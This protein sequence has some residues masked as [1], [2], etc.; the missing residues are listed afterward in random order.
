[1]RITPQGRLEGLHGFFRSPGLKHDITDKI[2]R[3][4][5]VGLLPGNFLQHGQSLIIVHH[6]WIKLAQHGQSI[7]QRLVNGLRFTQPA[8]DGN[9]SA[10][11]DRHNSAHHPVPAEQE[12]RADCCQNT[13]D[14]ENHVCR[15][16]DFPELIRGRQPEAATARAIH[17]EDCP[18]G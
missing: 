6:A 1:M 16:C 2:M 12:G 13:G 8:I 10:Q 5:I 3:L 7:R 15:A 17:P 4:R 18:Q 9:T 14:Q 11:N